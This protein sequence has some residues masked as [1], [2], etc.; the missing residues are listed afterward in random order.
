MTQE[1]CDQVTKHCTDQVWVNPSTLYPITTLESLVLMSITDLESIMSLGGTF[2]GK[3][4]HPHHVRQRDWVILMSPQG[5]IPSILY[6]WLED[7]CLSSMRNPLSKY[8][9][10]PLPG[11]LILGE[12]KHH[13]TNIRILKGGVNSEKEKFTC[14]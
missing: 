6:K 7:N 10:L 14:E 13:S 4:D 9:G 5:C 11:A 3:G 8:K 1:N 2:S 12:S